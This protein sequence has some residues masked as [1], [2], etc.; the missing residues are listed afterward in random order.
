MTRLLAA[1]L[2]LGAVVPACSSGGCSNYSEVS[3]TSCALGVLVNGEFFNL[4]CQPVPGG[5]LGRPLELT[6]FLA[7]PPPTAPL[8][9]A[10]TGVPIWREIALLMKPR[11]CSIEGGRG[12]MVQQSDRRVSDSI[13]FWRQG[14]GRLDPAFTQEVT[15]RLQ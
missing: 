11:V 3:A 9:A 5:R 10:I 8:A 14:L 15:S 4:T 13:L 6:S 2:L 7:K 12:R 1:I